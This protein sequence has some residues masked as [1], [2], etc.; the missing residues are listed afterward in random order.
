MIRRNYPLD[1]DSSEWLL[2]AQ[3]EHARVSHQ[4]AAAWDGML[5]DAPAGVRDEFLHAVLHHDDGWLEWRT[6]PKIDP[7]YGRP[8]GFTEMPPAE[9]QA[10]WSRSI[11][12]CRQRG[13]LA[14]WVVASHFIDLQKKQDDDFAQWAR[15]LGEQ[16]RHRTDWLAEW[17][18]GSEHHTT[19][20]ADECLFLLQTFDWLSLW[21]CCRAPIAVTDPA[22][23][24]VLGNAE[25]GFSTVTFHPA[26]PQQ[27]ANEAQQTYQQLRV[28]PWP[29]G[30]D[31]GY[32]LSVS[33]QRLPAR[34]YAVDEPLVG[35]P[36]TIE[37]KLVP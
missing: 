31:A 33:A 30:S 11:D 37:W 29:F 24:L 25:H 5:S 2:I 14:G 18:A 9:A 4:L 28:E 34:R 21:L 26:G 32:E 6:A 12:D 27:S 8:Y 1:S 36:L 35:E 19:S 13:L 17:L 16:D 23:Q 10:I 7:A 15:W 22:E 20:L 3:Q